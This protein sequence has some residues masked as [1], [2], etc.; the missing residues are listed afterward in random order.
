MNI[1]DL[2]SGDLQKLFFIFVRLA[3]IMMVIP[4]YG[5]QIIPLQVKLGLALLLTIIVSPIINGQNMTLEVISLL[6]FG[7]GIARNVIVGLSIGFIPLLLFAGVRLGGELIGIQI[8]FEI[9]TVLDPLSQIRISLIAQFEYLLAILVFISINGHLYLLEGI[10]K[11]FQIVPL[12]GSLLPNRFGESLVVLSRD[13][14]VIGLKIAA[15]V[16]VTIMLTNVGLGILGR[17]MPQMNIFL[18]GFPLQIGV[19]L[20]TLGFTIPLF[21]YFFEK[22]F[23]EFFQKWLVLI[24]LL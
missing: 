6:D 20:I 11:S 24:S 16:L 3:A 23:Y 17:T 12:T 19:G 15:P 1:F 14:F 22:L 9:S 5:Q 2:T 21:V 18:V 13:M 8:G 10:V 4:F 7:L